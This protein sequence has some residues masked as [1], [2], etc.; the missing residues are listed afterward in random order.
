[1]DPLT[2]SLRE[3]VRGEVVPREAATERYGRDASHLIGHPAAGVRPLDTPDVVRLVRWARAHRVPLVARGGGSSL[4]GESVPSPGSVVVDFSGW[5][6]VLEVDPDD[7]LA[8]VGPGVINHDLHRRLSAEGLF[9]PPNPGSWTT[10]TLGGNVATNASGPRSF[11]YGTTRHWVA[12]LEVVLGTGETVALGGRTTKRSVG[13]DLLGLFVGSEGILGFVT[14]VTVHL[15]VRP[16]RRS[17]IVVPLPPGGSPG[18]LA[19][20]IARWPTDRLSAVEYLDLACARA[21]AEEARGR[22]P[23]DR[24]LLLLELESVDAD[25]ETRGLERVAAWLADLGVAEDPVVVPDADELWTLRGRS[26]LAL[27]RLLGER[28]REDVAVPLSQLDA[29]FDAVAR[30][31]KAHGV[32]VPT[33]GHVG[34]GNLHPNFVLDPEG[35]AAGAVRSELLAATRRLSGTISA[36]HGVGALKAPHLALELDP[37]ALGLLRSVKRRCDPDGLLNPGKVLP[38]GG[39]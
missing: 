16:P 31:G 30:I 6:A 39:E 28:I 7:R 18:P 17:G 11:K 37:P 32:D 10:S 34:D 27:D 22:F 21:L 15:A 23:A 1:V 9:F 12:A 14:E 26:G 2:E 4:D 25:E 13:P 33:F 35:P 29:L 38:P 5:A 20:S 8:R 3:A 19:R 24:A 36:E